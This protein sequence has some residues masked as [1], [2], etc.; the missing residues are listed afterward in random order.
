MV[1]KW[2]KYLTDLHTTIW[3]ED[4]KLRDKKPPPTEEERQEIKQKALERI[5]DVIPGRCYRLLILFS[6]PF[7]LF[8]AKN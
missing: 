3:G 1:E 4:D 6:L 2:F 8:L 7:L 5:I